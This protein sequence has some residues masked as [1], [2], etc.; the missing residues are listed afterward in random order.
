[1]PFSPATQELCGLGQVIRSLT[2]HLSLPNG[3]I[4]VNVW[5]RI[6]KCLARA[7]YLMKGVC[8]LRK[9]ETRNSLLRAFPLVIAKE[10]CGVKRFSP[11]QRPPI[12]CFAQPS[13]CA[14]SGERKNTTSAK[15]EMGQ[16]RR[17]NLSQQNP[18]LKRNLDNLCMGLTS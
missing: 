9:V 7:S 8:A 6:G 1:M 17:P 3:T 5:D 16:S 4:V 18:C 13:F 12:E 2:S 11:I 14:L 15:E 10:E